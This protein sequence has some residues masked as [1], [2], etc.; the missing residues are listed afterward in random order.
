MLKDGQP[1]KPVI[2]VQRPTGKAMIVDGHHRALAT[3]EV[4]GRVIQ[5]YIA[6]VPTQACPWDETHDMQ[7]GDRSG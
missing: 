2:L 7:T 5:V 4:G 6:K 3:K 1:L